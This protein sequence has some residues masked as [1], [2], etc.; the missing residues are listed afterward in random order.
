MKFQ[1][2]NIIV[3]T[4]KIHRSI[5][6]IDAEL[7]SYIL[8]KTELNINDIE[9]YQILNKSID[10]RKKSNIKLI[11]RVLIDCKPHL[12][13]V[14][15]GKVYEE[16]PELYKNLEKCKNSAI[17]V[18]TGPAGLMNALVLAK[19]GCNPIILDRGFNVEQRRKDINNFLENRE[20]NEDSNYLY[21]EG[22]A[23]T[24]SDGKLYTRKRDART[25]FILD[26]FVDAG[27]SDDIL[28]LSHPHIGSD[29]LPEVVKN[30][31]E[32]IEELG[33]EFRWG[34]KV[35]DIV[36]DGNKCTGVILEDGT[37]L[38]ADKIV[39]AAGH[40]SRD[41]IKQLIKQDAEHKLKDFQIGCRIEH[42]QTFINKIRFG[43]EYV[44]RFLSIP[45]YNITSRPKAAD[46]ASATSFCMCPGGEVIP[47]V[48]ESGNLTTN[49][50]SEFK[51]DGEFA[52]SALIVNQKSDSFKDADEAFEFLSNIEKTLYKAGGEDYTCPAQNAYSFCTGDDYYPDVPT[53]YQLGVVGTKLNEMLPEKTVEALTEALRFF[54]SS[55]PGFMQTGTLIG[56]ETKVSSPVRFIR[57]KE[58]MQSSI[59]NLYLIGEGAGCAGGIISAAIDGLKCAEKIIRI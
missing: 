45:E 55:M 5:S 20:L 19:A 35:V 16:K 6:N 58:T 50:M 44:S 2:D 37:E 47:A 36:K 24:Y 21:G 42:K 38:L 56:I 43:T 31:R 11:Y 52:N 49:G 40:S 34:N 57:D 14:Q 18:G 3:D 30:I 28:Y 17:V 33:G 32:Q 12:T 15:N 59:E 13:S 46:I 23:G 39:I 29:V 26:S 7:T 48:C 41:L 51:R 54:E 8:K 22:G 1:I 27:A 10:A 4:K 9:S 53:S 25:R